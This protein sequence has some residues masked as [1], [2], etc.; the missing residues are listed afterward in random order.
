MKKKMR[1]SDSGRLNG[2]ENESVKES[3]NGRGS[4]NGSGTVGGKRQPDS[5]CVKN[6]QKKVCLET[7]TDLFLS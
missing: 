5:N 2:S 4:E 7:K 3:E 1:E 6:N